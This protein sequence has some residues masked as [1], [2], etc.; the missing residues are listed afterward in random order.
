MTLI[1]TE[2]SEELYQAMGPGIEQSGGSAA[3]TMAGV[4]SFGGTC[5]YIGKI[6]DDQLGEVFAH[7]LQATGVSFSCPPSTVGVPT[8]RCLIVVTPDATAHDEHLPR[9]QRAARPGRRRRRP[10][11]QRQGH[12]PRGLLVGQ[13]RGRWRRTARPPRPPMRRAAGCRS[14]CPTRSAWPATATEFLDLVESQV[15]V[16]FANEPEITELYEVDLVR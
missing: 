7:D 3:N 4:A 10:D 11:R 5:A 1:D 16:L 12:L 9:R 6:A 2:R 14:R 15:D 8:G 13:A